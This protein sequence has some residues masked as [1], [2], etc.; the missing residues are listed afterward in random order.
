MTPRS[1]LPPNQCLDVA[2]LSFKLRE[3]GTVSCF[4]AY[5]IAFV[6]RTLPTCAREG[7][8]STGS[9]KPQYNGWAG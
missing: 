5:H 8:L 4:A 3:L 1:S 7:A 2:E 6:R 9:K